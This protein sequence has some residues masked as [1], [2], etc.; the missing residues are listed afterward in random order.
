MSD[1]VER[2]IGD[3][4]VR[5]DRRACIGSG[6]CIKVCPTLFQLDDQGIVAFAAGADQVA[7]EDV[8][9]ACAVC[10]VEVFEV[11]DENGDLLVP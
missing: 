1:Y 5:V 11:R 7:R 4:A 8:V 3:L 6:N 9:E 2:K 10:P